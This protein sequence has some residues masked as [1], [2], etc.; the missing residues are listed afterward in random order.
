M[1]NFVCRIFNV[2]ATCGRSF[3]RAPATKISNASAL[4]SLRRFCLC[5]ACAVVPDACVVA[6]AA[7]SVKTLTML[8][9]IADLVGGCGCLTLDQ[10]PPQATRKP[11][12]ALQL[13]AWFSRQ[14]AT[15][16]ARLMRLQQTICPTAQ[17]D[18][19]LVRPQAHWA[20]QPTS[21]FMPDNQYLAT[22]T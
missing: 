15:R 3:D 10:C 20:D 2:Y 6:Q 8:L 9:C 21:T 17:P 19:R 22:M 5:V 16:M 12:G 1:D 18:H 7:R 11:T 14:Q 13:P 4:L